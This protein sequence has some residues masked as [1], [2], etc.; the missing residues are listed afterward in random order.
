MRLYGSKKSLN[1]AINQE[2]YCVG[3]GNVEKILS[4]EKSTCQLNFCSLKSYR[5]STNYIHIRTVV[6]LKFRLDDQV[7]VF[8]NH[9]LDFS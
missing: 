6:F 4:D 5:V 8:M 9:E 2:W 7:R 3:K 1:I